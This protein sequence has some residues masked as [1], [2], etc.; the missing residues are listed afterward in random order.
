M[1]RAKLG[2]NFLVNRHAAEKMVKKFLPVNGPILEIGPGKG[3]LTQVLIT[4]CRDNRIVAIELDKSLFS[5]LKEKI[6]E[7][8]SVEILNRDILKTD[9]HQL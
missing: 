8:E 7:R 4:H 9:L 1:K 5:Q 3:I 2:Q 6:T